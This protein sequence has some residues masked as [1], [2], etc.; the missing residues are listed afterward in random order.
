MKK[1]KSILSALTFVLFLFLALASGE[2]DEYIKEQSIEG[3]IAKLNCDF[4]DFS[5]PTDIS[6]EYGVRGFIH[7]V[8]FKVVKENEDVEKVHISCNFRLEDKYGVM[9]DVNIPLIF[10]SKHI[11]E[12]ELRK[13]GD[14]RDYTS[15]VMSSAQDYPM[16]LI[17]DNATRE[18]L[19]K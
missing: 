11:E 17:L 1:K 2:P 8:L 5:F 13:Y 15:N 7:D 6:S 12:T 19:T 10:D 9:N 4:G 16:V 14:F 18:I 3:E